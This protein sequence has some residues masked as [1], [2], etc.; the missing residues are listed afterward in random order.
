[1]DKSNLLTNAYMHSARLLC[2]KELKPSKD[3]SNAIR[4]LE[5][6]VRPGV[7]A[8]ATRNITL[9]SFAVFLPLSILWF[10]L[11]GGSILLIIAACIVPFII[12]HLFSE[13][14]K[15]LVKAKVFGAL[16]TSVETLI[17]LIVPLKFGTN[18]ENAAKFAAEHGK[19]GIA[20]DLKRALWETWSGKKESMNYQFAQLAEKW[21][22][23]SA[24]F[25]RTMYLI[26]TALTEKRQRKKV[27]LLD[28][29]LETS[30]MGTK[31]E[32]EGYVNSL[33]IP[34]LILFSLGTI[35]PLL[36]ISLLPIIAY[37][38]IGASDPLSLGVLLSLSLA[39]TYAYSNS[40]LEKRPPAFSQPDI[41]Q[42]EEFPAPGKIR[43]LGKD[44]PALAFSIILFLF[45]GSPGIIFLLTLSPVLA[46]PGGFLG[47]ILRDINTLT[48]FWAFGIAIAV[49]CYGYANPRLALRKQIKELDSE[50]L[51]AVY[52]LANKLSE[53]RPPENALERVAE[54]Q[55]GTRVSRLFKSVVKTVRHSNVTL[56]EALFDNT[57]G[58]M[59]KVYSKTAHSLMWLFVYSTEKGSQVASDVLFTLADHLTD[60]QSTEDDLKTMVS[61]NIS[62]LKTTVLF[63]APLV[64]GLSITLYSVIKH[65]LETTSGKLV[66]LGMGQV[67]LGMAGLGTSSA[68][69]ITVE[70]L[71]LM[72]GIYILLLVVILVRYVSRIENG[73]DE[74][75]MKLTIA[76]FL[77]V[78]LTIFTLSL[79]VS[80]NFLGG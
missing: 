67:N 55:S 72:V 4:L 18:L 68:P 11:G 23:Y 45:I 46:L 29:A 62:M 74:V 64:G 65:T 49:Y 13:Y 7:I 66:D 36:F 54:L 30:L 41:P 15:I 61:K 78:A 76:K 42:L 39:G 69:T 75:T 25:K 37:F 6:K 33:Y 40:V 79:L 44:F 8:G 26:R 22:L 17:F 28:K 21:G 20:A 9:L 3:L 34:T 38:G 16:E 35:L 27:E 43:I 5:W 31:K 59:N 53:G 47:S 24:S 12:N 71:Q 58:V 60:L 56:K 14:P 73:V 50:V 77:P 10:F 63:F 48:L 80:R 57:V 19:G 2:T 32:F 70:V 52:L 1:M 51:D